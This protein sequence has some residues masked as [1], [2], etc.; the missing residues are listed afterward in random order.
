MI[1][2]FEQ[3]LLGC[4]LS[5][6]SNLTGLPDRA[7]VQRAPAWRSVIA[8]STGPQHR[9]SRPSCFHLATHYYV[10]LACR[11]QGELLAWATLGRPSR[12]PRSPNAPPPQPPPRSL[13]LSP[14]S[15]SRHGIQTS[16]YLI[17]FLIRRVRYTTHARPGP[18]RADLRRRVG[19]PEQAAPLVGGR[20]GL[21]RSLVRALSRFSV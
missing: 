6:V 21:L 9:P 13:P 2:P 16:L 17:P 19:T 3:A 11:R 18:I 20:P 10:Y 8:R 5:K 14:P 1:K 7:G 15:T 12:S 4:K